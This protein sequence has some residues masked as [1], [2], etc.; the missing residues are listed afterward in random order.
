LIP[1]LDQPDLSLFILRNAD[2]NESGNAQFIITS[3]HLPPVSAILPHGPGVHEWL[4]SQYAKLMQ[5]KAG[6]GAELATG[7]QTNAPQRELGRAL[8]RGFGRELYLK[9]APQIFK[10]TFWKLSSKLGPRFKSIQIYSDDPAIPWELM[11][12]VSPDGRL[13]LEYLGVEFNM[14]RWHISQSTSQVERSPQM[15][16]LNRL[17]VIA[18]SYRGGHALPGQQKELRALRRFRG[19]ERLSGRLSS[20]QKL[21][22]DVPEGIIHFAGHG[23]RG[24]KNFEYSIKLEDADLDLMMWRGMVNGWDKS[25]PLLFFNACEVG[26]SVRITNFVEGWAPAVLDAGGSGY[27]GA[28]WPVADSGAAEFSTYFYS[29]LNKSLK[30]GPT[31]VSSVLKETRRKFLENGDFT[32]LAYVFYGDANLSL[33]SEPRVKARRYRAPSGNGKYSPRQRRRAIS[34]TKTRRGR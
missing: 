28:L 26:Q 14:G 34:A 27:I 21:F 3:P 23:A 25:H 10:E 24:R 1:E 19:Y 5:L 17:V 29:T 4:D 9:F 30:G 8:M 22:S 33:F 31:S 20:I 7:L 12:P 16:S 15:L 13:E 32:F 6:R 18:P 2:G 11:R